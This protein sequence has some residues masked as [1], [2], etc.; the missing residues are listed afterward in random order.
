MSFSSMPF[1][2]CGSRLFKNVEYALYY[3]I[4]SQTVDVCVF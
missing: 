4:H 1:I 2:I 3:T